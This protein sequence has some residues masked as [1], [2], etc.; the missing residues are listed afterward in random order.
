MQHPQATW[1]GFPTTYNDPYPSSFATQ[2]VES[3]R[4][5]YPQQ[6]AD[7]HHAYGPLEVAQG[8]APFPQPSHDAAAAT[9][10]GLRA[11]AQE[12]RPRSEGEDSESSN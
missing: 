3:Y 11:E 5:W 4:Y 9:D 6:T 10:R 8:Q 12:Y 7:T 2:V 1:N